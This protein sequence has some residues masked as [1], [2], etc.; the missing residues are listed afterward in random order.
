[1]HQQIDLQNLPPVKLNHLRL[2]TDSTGI[3]QHAT[4]GVVSYKSGYTVDDNARA[5]IAVLRFHNLLN[6]MDSE[7]LAM[8]Y[9]GFLHYTQQPDGIFHNTVSFERAFV[10][11]EPTWDC[12]GRALWACG[13]AVDSRLYENAKA[14]AKKMLDDALQNI[15]KLEDARP[16]AF[17]LMGLHH[18]FHAKPEQSDLKEKI[19]LLG[20]KLLALLQQS[21][22]EGWFWFEDALTYCNA[23]LPHALF[24]AFEST[25][26]RRFL[27][28]AEQSF[29]FLE[30]KTVEGE[31]FIPVGQNGWLPK[32]G[33]KALFDQQ[34]IEAS[35]MVEA[36]VAAFK[37][38]GKERYKKT[39][40]T[41]FEWF[42]GR[43]SLGAKLY[44]ETNGG[45]FDGLTET[46]VNLNQGAES[47]IAYLSAR[48]SVEE[49]ARTEQRSLNH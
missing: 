23:R 22:S 19:I 2:L 43:N 18:Y 33:A 1:M 17:A 14:T 11:E 44:D 5:L 7:T 41:A 27:D 39:A 12:Y 31:I 21:S 10:Q 26:E 32:G 9:L 40:L 48:L 47:T 37:A 25:K 46:E 30:E 38:N 49:L 35:S 45:C 16:V 42:F 8:I 6:G 24:L 15:S 20:D 36:A 28:A 34:P 3:I 29:R 4:H 13:Y